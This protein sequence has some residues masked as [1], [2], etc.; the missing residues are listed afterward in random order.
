MNPVAKQ[1]LRL[2]FFFF[3]VLQPVLIWASELLPLGG[4]VTVARLL[5]LLLVNFVAGTFLLL[6]LYTFYTNGTA[7]PSKVFPLGCRLQIVGQTTILWDKKDVKYVAM[8]CLSA[9]NGDLEPRFYRWQFDTPPPENGKIVV[10]QSRKDFRHID[11]E[12]GFT[13]FIL[14]KKAPRKKKEEAREFLQGA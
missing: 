6:I 12:A 2:S 7:L 10:V 14:P 13:C 5:T 8:G 4:T 11:A 9:P 1:I 3:V